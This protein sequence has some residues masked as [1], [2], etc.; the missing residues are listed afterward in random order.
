[1]AKSGKGKKTKAN[2]APK[3]TATGAGSSAESAPLVPELPLQA[4]SGP[5]QEEARVAAAAQ[6]AAAALT[7]PML[8]S[9]SEGDAH[10]VAAWLHKG[11]DVDAGCAEGGGTLLVAAAMGG[12][13]AVVRMLLQRGASINLQDSFGHTRVPCARGAERAEQLKGSNGLQMFLQRADSVGLGRVGAG[14][15]RVYYGVYI[16]VILAGACEM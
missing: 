1:M 8:K 12:Q 14:R 2:P 5:H 7:E 16:H 9:A 6:K 10:T 3:A 11:G 13:E 15:D 4:A